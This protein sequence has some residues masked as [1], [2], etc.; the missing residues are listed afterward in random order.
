VPLSEKH[1]ETST[2]LPGM[3]VIALFSVS[4]LLILPN[5]YLISTILVTTSATTVLS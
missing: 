5:R 1:N 3:S 4:L 2:V